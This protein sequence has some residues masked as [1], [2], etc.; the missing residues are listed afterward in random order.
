MAASIAESLRAARERLGWSRETLAHHSGVSWSAI[1]QIEAGRRTD[2]RLSS[3]SALAR[4]LGVTIDHLSQGG[5]SAPPRLLQHRAL[6]HRS[7]DEFLAT[8]VPF[9]QEGVDRSDAMLVVATASL[10]DALR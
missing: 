8:A 3:L 6:V 10:V 9:L 5:T 4:A 2:V 1:A 7:A